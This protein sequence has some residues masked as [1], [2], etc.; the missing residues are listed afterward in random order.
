MR[1][2]FFVLF[3]LLGTA[4]YGQDLPNSGF[5]KARIVEPDR[6]IQ[7]ELKPVSSKPHLKKEL[8][9]AWYGANTIHFTQ[10]GYSGRLLNGWY[11]EYYLNKNLKLQGFY[12]GGLKTGPWKEWKEDGSLTSQ[13]NWKNGTILPDS[14]VSFWKRLPLIHKKK[15]VPEKPAIGSKGNG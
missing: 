8:F 5:D 3:C 9:Y 7:L 10:G 14:T 4:A 1:K 13:V 12:K 6:V 15:R 11:N 2:I